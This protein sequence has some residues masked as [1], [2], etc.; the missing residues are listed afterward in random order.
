MIV[1][2]NLPFSIVDD[3]YFND[4]INFIRPSVQIPSS[5]TVR[6]LIFKTYE[7]YQ[8]NIA[9]E[10]PENVEGTLMLDDWTCISHNHFCGYTFKA[11]LQKV[12]N[13][14]LVEKDHNL[15]YGDG[16]AV[17][18]KEVKLKIVLLKNR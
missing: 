1:K 18:I 13:V 4:F 3:F 9:K 2:N 12:I 15:L 10:L 14:G 5:K 16:I 7:K 8:N 6:K 11:P 17:E